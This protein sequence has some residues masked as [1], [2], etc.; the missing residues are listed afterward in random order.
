MADERDHHE[1]VEGLHPPLARGEREGLLALGAGPGVHD[2]EPDGPAAVGGGL[3]AQRDLRPPRPGALP[4][5]AR[6]A[7]EG[8]RPARLDRTELRDVE[9]RLGEERRPVGRRGGPALALALRRHRVERLQPALEVV[10]D[11]RHVRDPRRRVVPAHHAAQRGR[12]EGP[13]ALPVPERHERRIAGGERRPARRR[14]G[15]APGPRAGS[16]CPA[17][18]PPRRRRP[19]SPGRGGPR[20]RGPG[21]RAPRGSS[22]PG[23][24]ARSWRRPCVAGRSRAPSTT[25]SE[26][27]PGRSR[28]QPL[29]L[30]GR[31]H[32]LRRRRLAR[33]DRRLERV[34]ARRASRRRRGP[35]AGRRFGS[36]SRQARIVALDR[37]VEVGD[38]RGRLDRPLVAVLAREL[39]EPLALEGAPARD[40]LVDQ[41]GRARRCRCGR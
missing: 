22:R 25:T 41:R 26:A 5:G 39:G 27:G 23:S 14:S 31:R 24:G 15:P 7:V 34:A 36:F 37:R 12:R 6:V 9:P 13:R 32:Q 19:P 40:E 11:A 28:A 30:A 2:L 21:P 18:S 4:G 33:R 1:D 35:R 38:D 8:R 10:L 16:R 29:G 3:D 20:D 17:R